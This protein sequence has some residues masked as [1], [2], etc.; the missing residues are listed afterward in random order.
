MSKVKFISKDEKL[1]SLE[2]LAG[3]WGVGPNVALKFYNYGIHS[4]QELRENG[5][6]LLNKLQ[7]IGLQYHDDISQKIPRSEVEEIYEKVKETT[8]RL[9]PDKKLIIETC[10]SYRRGRPS[11][12]DV[13]VI[14]TTE[15]LY[16]ELNTTRNMLPS[17]VEALEDDG[18][19]V[20]KLG[21]LRYSHNGSQTLLGI[22]KLQGDSRLNRRLDIKVYPR[23]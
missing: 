3:V 10:G 2:E 23:S 11:S 14:I 9:F 17:I 20:E 1:K 19:L 15:S 12:G 18:F 5:Q 8:E 16:D 4:V 13:D 7:K 22:C 21:A 6:H